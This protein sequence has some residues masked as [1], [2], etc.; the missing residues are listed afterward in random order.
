[1]RTFR[2]FIASSTPA[3]YLAQNLR[4]AINK[5]VDEMGR[6]PSKEKI[7]IQPVLWWEEFQLG[8][9][10]LG[11]LI[12]ECKKCDFAAIL[13]TEDDVTLKKGLA[14]LQPRDN[15]IFEAGLF[16]GGLSM[17]SGRVFL[18]T[19]VKK[20]PETLPSDLLG[21]VYVEIK[22]PEG[23]KVSVGDS[24]KSIDTAA[25]KIIDGMLKKGRHHRGEIP[26]IPEQELM[27]FER[28]EAEAGQLVE[29]SRIFVHTGQPMEALNPG[30]A[31]RVQRNIKNAIRYRYFFYADENA[32]AMI[33]RLIWTLGAAGVE[34]PT[35]FDKKMK[36]RQNPNLVLDNLKSIYRQLN[37]HFLREEP[38]F[39]LCIHN[40][41]VTQ[42]AV[43]YLR[44]PHSDP[45]KFIRWCGGRAAKEIAESFLAMRKNPPSTSIF[46]STANV[47]LDAE[48]E[49]RE[50]L[51][52]AI[53]DQFPDS[54]ESEVSKLCFGS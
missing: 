23:D 29:G 17:D 32:V 42:K 24:D 50:R 54:I 34:G 10:T 15:C 6:D 36:I 11:G 52:R 12:D 45:I 39:E 47:D 53:F 30:F 8:D 48:S 13:L 4:D 46:R 25:R 18:L 1:M 41:E 19:S 35:V 40:S 14:Q 51:C 37:V 20:T 16:T 38:Q 26:Y 21:I 33:A 31:E 2:I 7:E 28:L 5:R 44:V 49:F 43:C 22:V 27:S 3:Q 9:S